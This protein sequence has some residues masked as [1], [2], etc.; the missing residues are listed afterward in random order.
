MRKAAIALLAVPII[1]A[2]YVGALLRRSTL[3]RVG[4]ALGLALILGVGVISAGL[5]TT[6]IATPTTPIVPLTR[7][8][9]ARPSRP[10]QRRRNR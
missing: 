5:P 9:S 4:L 2:L 6:T 1:V 3:A 8:R 7:R 10:D